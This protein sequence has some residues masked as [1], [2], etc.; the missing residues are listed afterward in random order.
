MVT[1]TTLSRD[2]EML[3]KHEYAHEDL[4]VPP[5]LGSA[6]SFA[7]IPAGVAIVG[8]VIAAFRTPS[9]RIRTYVEHFAAGVVVAV[10]AAELLPAAI[11]R[12]SA[13]AIAI[14]FGLGTLAMLLIAHFSEGAEGEEDALPRPGLAWPG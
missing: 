2:A 5:A 13:I 12:R 14:G 10:A 8:A 9:P 3:L 11:K 4:A 7:L 6:L 1:T